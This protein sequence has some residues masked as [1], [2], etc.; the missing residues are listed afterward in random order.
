MV[1]LWFIWFNRNAVVYGKISMSPFLA[2][3]RIL[4]LYKDFMKNNKILFQCL[5]NNNLNWQ[6]P[7]GLY[8]KVNCDASWNSEDRSGGIGIVVRDSSGIFLAIKAQHIP[9]CNSVK[10]SHYEKMMAPK[11]E[12]EQDNSLLAPKVEIEQYWLLLGQNA[13]QFAFIDMSQFFYLLPKYVLTQGRS[14]WEGLRTWPSFLP[15]PE[16]LLR[17]PCLRRGQI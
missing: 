11:V 15:L 6:K 16:R 2:G 5:N 1:A 12:I 4:S 10:V 3:K 17:K 14:M 8:R 9:H 7:K 13:T